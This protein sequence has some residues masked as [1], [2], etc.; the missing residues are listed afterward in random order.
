[1][2]WTGWGGMED[3]GVERGVRG[4]GV[5]CE[6]DDRDGCMGFRQEWQTCWSIAKASRERRH[7]R[8]RETK[9]KSEGAQSGEREKAVPGVER[10]GR[11]SPPLS[12]WLGAAAPEEIKKCPGMV[13]V[14]VLVVVDGDKLCLASEKDEGEK[15]YFRRTENS[16]SER[17]VE[18]TK[19]KRKKTNQVIFSS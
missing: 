19:K 1:M 2:G 15:K 13:V 16:A 3:V 9:E 14:V 6:K 12:V 10:L 11:A 8:E 17:A 5:H 18:I 7:D 4:A